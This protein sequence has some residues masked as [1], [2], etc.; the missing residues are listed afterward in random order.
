MK[1]L[2]NFEDRNGNE[3]VKFPTDVLN[4]VNEITISNAATMGTPSI[5]ATGTDVDIDLNLITKGSGVLKINGVA[6]AVN[7]SESIEKW[8]STTYTD[9]SLLSANWI[10]SVAPFTYTLTLAGVKATGTEQTFLPQIS[11]TTTQLEAIQGAN[12]Q[13][14]G[15]ALNQVTIKAYGE[16]RIIDLPLRYKI[17]GVK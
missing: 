9:V 2:T 1:V 16:K 15:Q 13:D 11:A 12:L 5:A 10:G 14:G 4:A 6:L 17:S 7:Q 3:I 8:V